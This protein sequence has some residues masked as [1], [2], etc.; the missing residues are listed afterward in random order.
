MTSQTGEAPSGDPR[1]S[2]GP[3]PPGSQPPEAAEVGEAAQDAGGSEVSGEPVEDDQAYLDRVR[4]EI[5]DEVRRRRAAGD[6]PPSFERKL[7][8]LFARYTPTG[9]ADDYFAEALKLADRAA[10]FDIDVPTGSRREVRGLVKWS[11]W[12][13]EAWF[14]RYVVDQLNHF[15][16]ALMRTVHLLDE[17]LAD[18]EHDV[19]LL[20]PGAL[21]AEDELAPPAD[22]GAYTEQVLARLRSGPGGRV[23]HG[24]CGDGRLVEALGAAGVGI[25]GIDPGTAAADVA[26]ARGLDVRRD[27][28]AGHLAALVDGVLGGLVLSGVIDRCAAAQRHRLV[29]LAELKLAP[30][31][32]LAVV[33][34]PPAAWEA[35]AGPL[36][37][38]LAQ[39]RPWHPQTWAA[40][41]ASTGFADVETHADDSVGVVLATK[42]VPVR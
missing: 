19:A 8:E 42:P 22:P 29:Q 36:A 21:P 32:T 24:E 13:A 17:R 25:Y 2:S 7:D 33:S 5:D 10:F 40:V 39:G 35:A 23:L 3:V 18:V 27:D 15:S 26:A 41:L 16:A 38:D 14:V 30:G 6:F 12:Q 4:R 31:A 28:T 9:E 1:S 34:T 37:A 20:A 11:L